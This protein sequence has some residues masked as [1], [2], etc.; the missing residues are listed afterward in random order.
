MK[1]TNKQF[2]EEV[3]SFIKASTNSLSESKTNGYMMRTILS[4]ILDLQGL[5]PIGTIIPWYGGQSITS[6]DIPEGYLLCDGTKGTPDLRDSYLRGSTFNE[7]GSFVGSNS[8]YIHRSNLPK[9]TIKSNTVEGSGAHK[10]RIVATNTDAVNENLIGFSADINAGSEWDFLVNYGTSDSG[11][12][13]HESVSEFL[14]DG[15]PIDITPLSFNVVYLMYVG[16]EDTYEGELLEDT[17]VLDSWLDYLKL[18]KFLKSTGYVSIRL[19][20]NSLGVKSKGSVITSDS[21]IPINEI[22]QDLAYEPSSP[23]SNSRSLDISMEVDTPL[24]SNSQLLG[25][26]LRQPKDTLGT[27]KDWDSNTSVNSMYFSNPKD[28][29][30]YGDHSILSQSHTL[31]KSK[32]TSFTLGT[33]EKFE[34]SVIQGGFEYGELHYEGSFEFNDLPNIKEADWSMSYSI[35]DNFTG[36]PTNPNNVTELTYELLPKNGVYELRYKFV[37]QL[38]NQLTDL[39]YYTKPGERFELKIYLVSEVLKVKV[40]RT[41]YLYVTTNNRVPL[42]KDAGVLKTSNTTTTVW[43]NIYCSART[44]YGWE[45]Y[46]EDNPQLVGTVGTFTKATW[47]EHRWM[48]E[49]NTYLYFNNLLDLAKPVYLRPKTIRGLHRLRYEFGDTISTGRG[50]NACTLGQTGM[51]T[52]ISDKGNSPYLSSSISLSNHGLNINSTVNGDYSLYRSKN[53]LNQDNVY[54]DEE[55]Q[56]LRVPLYKFNEYADNTEIW[57][58]N[59][60]TSGFTNLERFGLGNGVTAVQF[61]L[62]GSI[63]YPGVTR[64]V[65]T[66]IPSVNSL[67]VIYSPTVT[68]KLAKWIIKGNEFQQCGASKIVNLLSNSTAFNTEAGY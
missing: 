23:T 58:V 29:K 36:L 43:N 68:T 33:K 44:I 55:A 19:G 17:I 47:S 18:N 24:V 13:N 62:A 8:K 22:T 50:P 63:G 14:G 30:H 20:S 26:D 67:I 11:T 57:S 40:P 4:K 54:W 12:H 1:L 52:F 66:N 49:F 10:H 9:D 45:Y 16:T 42:S 65:M 35:T 46:Q 21:I 61:Q 5:V 15:L 64:S 28:N 60:Q 31:V 6:M 48:T 39:T 32:Y 2:I 38:T 27:W 59:S 7:Q 37:I 51:V 3:N 41:M 56:L 53:I 34:Q 25:L